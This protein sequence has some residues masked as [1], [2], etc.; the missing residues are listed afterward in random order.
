MLVTTA[1]EPHEVPNPLLASAAVGVRGAR[2]TPWA[3]LQILAPHYGPAVT[4]R[5]TMRRYRDTKKAK[6]AGPS[7]VGYGHGPVFRG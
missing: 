7:L 4:G 6:R 2:G 3:G 1:L 5:R